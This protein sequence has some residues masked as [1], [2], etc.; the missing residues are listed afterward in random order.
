MLKTLTINPIR[1]CKLT[2]MA[3]GLHLLRIAFFLMEISYILEV[4]NVNLLG[5]AE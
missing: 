5:Q 4:G 3:W 2:I 1:R